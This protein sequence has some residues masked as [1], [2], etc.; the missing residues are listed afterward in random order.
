[1]ASILSSVFFFIIAIGVLIT[2]HEFGHFWVARKVGV[3]VIRFSVGF[4]KPLFSWRGA[5][6]E[7]EYVIAMLPLGG[8]VQML[9]E[10]EGD[11]APEE[12]DRAF[13]RQSLASRTAIVAAG[14]IFNFILAIAIYW[15]ILMIG[16]SGVKPIV[17]DINEASIAAAGGF[18]RGDVIT[19]VG[20]TKTV[21]WGMAAM[22][23]LDHSLGDEMVE[24]RVLEDGVVSKTRQLD[25][26]TP[27]L[28]LERKNLLGSLGINIMRPQIPAR[29][30]EVTPGGAADK[31]GIMG[32]DLLLTVDGELVGDWG[33]W[34][35]VVRTN[36]ENRLQVELERDGRVMMVDLRPARLSTKEGEIGRIG[37][38]VQYP[39]ELF[40]AF[41]AVERYGFFAAFNAAVVKTWDMSL[42][43]LRMLGNMVI[44]KVSVDNLS[45]PISIA[46][47]AGSSAG[48]GFVAFAGFLALISISLGVLNLLPIP[49]LDGGHLF[50]YLIEWIKGSV[51]S[52]ATQ[53]MGQR[54]GIALLAL[55]MI[56]A[57]YNDIDRLVG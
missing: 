13:N 28:E 42:L 7:T 44:G 33:K 43:T 18:Q 1:M 14:P 48:M 15:L 8:Y 39:K 24:V 16:V 31:A 50:Y 46:Q 10:R 57:F 12:L 20:D 30:G 51:V 36:A 6:D 45:G 40:E 29:I 2:V 52:E 4:G 11:V 38:T 47:Y 54:V 26:S 32:G 22:A 9:D 35:H 37:A 34:V 23:L 55:V 25:F 53:M 27:G 41:N 21:T 49:M 56:V 17:G 5:N 19:H 3:K